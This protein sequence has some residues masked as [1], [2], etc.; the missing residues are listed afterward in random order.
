LR[1]FYATDVHGS[2]R[3]FRKFLNA[4]DFYRAD[5]VLLGGD[6]TGKA[7]VPLV[8][9]N[10]RYEGQFLGEAVGVS[11]GEELE[12]LEQKIANTGYYAW[13]CT[14]EERDSV[15]QDAEAQHDLFVRLIVE[16]V[17]AWAAL[18]S[19]RLGSK[20]IPCL[21]NA[22]N[23]DPEE[24]DAALADADWVTFLEGRVVQLPDGT[25]VAS[26][27]YANMTIPGRQSSTSTARR[28]TRASIRGRSSERTSASRLA[29]AASRCI[30][31][32]ALHVARR[33]SAISRCSGCTAICTS[34]AERRRSVAPC[35]STREASTQ[36]G[37]S[38]GR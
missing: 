3:C 25:Q 16:R 23:D 24:V 35:A 14:R 34:H 33:S 4:A 7:I 13:R 9:S 36:R 8:A 1:L 2:E 19:E 37:S 5:A 27:G 10:G 15:Q 31:W 17:W 22:G 21:I 18:A 12:Q 26:C 32:E 28:T 6:I 20:G 38:A 29:P 11:E 30:P